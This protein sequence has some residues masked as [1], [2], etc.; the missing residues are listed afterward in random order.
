MQDLIEDALKSGR[1]MAGS[2]M[3]TAAARLARL[4]PGCLFVIKTATVSHTGIV[5]E[6]RGDGFTSVEGNTNEDG[7]DRGFEV[8]IMQRSY[9]EKDFL[10]LA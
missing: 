10:L 5:L 8:K 6:V 9:D 4:Q 1:F 3:T 2:G 7:G